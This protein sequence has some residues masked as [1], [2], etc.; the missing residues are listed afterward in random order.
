M[1][2]GNHRVAPLF[3]AGRRPDWAGAVPRRPEGYAGRPPGGASR[4]VTDPRVPGRGPPDLRGRPGGSRRRLRTGA[5]RRRRRAARRRGLGGRR[6]GLRGGRQPHLLHHPVDLQTLHLRPGPRRPGLRGG[7]R[8]DRGGA[9]GRGVQRAVAGGGLGPP[10]QP[11]DQRRRPGRPHPRGPARGVACGAV[12]AGRLRHL[13]LRR[14][15]AGDRRGRLPLRDGDRPP[16]SRHR[17]HAAQLRGHRGGRPARRRGLRPAVLA[18]GH[19]PRSGPDGRHPRQRRRAAG[20]RRAGG[21][22]RRW[23]AR[24]SAS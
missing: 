13:R 10:P 20:H 4:A 1:A 6:H 7:P 18:A 23:S 15:A 21:E 12:R 3:P 14:A 9:L 8:Q 19:H 2:G 22:P 24:S 17:P 5:G 16:Q 11:D